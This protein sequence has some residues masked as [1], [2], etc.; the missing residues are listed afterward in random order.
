MTPRLVPLMSR[1]DGRGKSTGRPRIQG[2]THCK[3]GH[4]LNQGNMYVNPRGTVVC[5]ECQREGKRRR[6][7]LS[8]SP[9]PDLSE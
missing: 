3:N 6:A 4:E 7:T 9:V 8:N 1:H 2:R 5:R